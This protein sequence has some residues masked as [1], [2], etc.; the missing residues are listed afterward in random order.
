[1]R[2]L[3]VILVVLAGGKVAALQWLHHAAADDVIISAYRPR[4]LDACASEAKRLPQP[5]DDRVWAQDVSLHLEIGS[6]KNR[7]YFWQVD[8]PSWSERFRNPYLHLEAGTAQS[9]VRCEYDIVNGRAST[10][11]L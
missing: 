8:R 5:V 3:V 4:A 9:R 2:M 1:M 10:A 6:R 11:R 7:V